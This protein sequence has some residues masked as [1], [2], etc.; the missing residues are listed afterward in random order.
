MFEDLL[1]LVQL[2]LANLATLL[3]NLSRNPFSYAVPLTVVIPVGET[4]ATARHGLDRGMNGAIVVGA[5][6]NYAIT[7]DLPSSGV[8]V[9]VRTNT[10]VTTNPLTVNLRVF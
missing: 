7:V 1:R 5:S 10:T 8:A 6:A 4:E 2:P 3:R 9:T